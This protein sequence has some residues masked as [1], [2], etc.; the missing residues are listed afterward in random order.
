MGAVLCVTYPH[1]SGIGG[2]AFFVTFPTA[3]VISRRYQGW[4]RQHKPRSTI[5]A[6]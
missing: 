4:D 6:Q 3:K 1:F 2:D 5:Q